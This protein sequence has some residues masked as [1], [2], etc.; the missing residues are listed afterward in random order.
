MNNAT[1]LDYRVVYLMVGFLLMP[2]MQLASTCTVLTY[3]ALSHTSYIVF[4]TLAVAEIN[5]Q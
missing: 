5:V 2:D 1:A 3:N 4:S